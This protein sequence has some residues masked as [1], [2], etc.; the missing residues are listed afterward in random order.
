MNF[1]QQ[2]YKADVNNYTYN[3]PETALD[4]N[5]EID[6][7]EVKDTV[8]KLRNQ[9]SP[10]SDGI[11]NELLKYRGPKL[12]EQLTKL[13]IRIFEEQM[14]PEEWRMS[15]LI[16][17]FKKGDKRTPENY[18]GI[19]LLHTT[20]KL[21]TKIVTSKFSMIHPADEQQ[22]CRSGRSCVDA[23]FMIRQIIEKPIEYNKPAYLCFIDLQ[24]A[25]DRIQLRHVLHLQCQKKIHKNVIK[26]IENIY[27]NTRVQVRSKG[28]LKLIPMEKG[29]REGDSVS[30][31]LFNVIMDEIIKSIHNQKVIKW[32]L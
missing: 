24:K 21:A 32:V 29:I 5:V 14:I 7:E 9:K 13:L 23:V 22:G 11:L 1:Y 18:R 27:T 26:L 31:L 16:T 6:S 12:L 10:R 3:I 15:T 30:P 8:Q 19:N 20:L 17:L 28:Q 4:T 25:F 2:L